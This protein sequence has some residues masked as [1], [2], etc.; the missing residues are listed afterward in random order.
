MTVKKDIGKL[1]DFF[2][3]ILCFHY[4]IR[5][6]HKKTDDKLSISLFV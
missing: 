2:V 4:S 5:N 6:D 3:A 1:A